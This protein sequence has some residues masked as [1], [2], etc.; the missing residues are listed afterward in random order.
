MKIIASNW[1]NIFGIFIVTLFYA[2]TSN[3]LNNDLDYSIFQ[4]IIAGLILV[5]LYGIIFWSLFVASLII[6]DLLLIVK[7]QNNIRQKLLIEWI[8][9]SGP[10]TYWGI[11][12]GEW[13]FLVAIVAF[14]ITQFCR[15]KLLIKALGA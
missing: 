11:K 9:I 6:L 7:K 8:V 15:E 13:I 3:Q 12:Y 5:C 10:F 14:A 4:S 1:I 2:V